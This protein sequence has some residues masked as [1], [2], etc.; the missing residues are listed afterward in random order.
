[1]KSILKAMKLACIVLTACYIAYA[2]YLIWANVN[3]IK[4]LSC[5]S[6]EFTVQSLFLVFVVAV[7]FAYAVKTNIAINKLR[8]AEK[9]ERSFDAINESRKQA[10]GNV[11]FL[12]IWL[13]VTAILSFTYS[14]V[15]FLRS[16]ID[17]SPHNGT[18]NQLFENF[19]LFMNRTVDF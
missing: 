16:N 17:C 9:N 12:L 5:I 10:M 2:I 4:V 8:E 13:M 14:F 18:K 7:F 19:I 1:M 6:S 15:K 11:W 3:N